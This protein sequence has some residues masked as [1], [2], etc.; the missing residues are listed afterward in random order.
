VL[1]GHVDAASIVSEI[2]HPRMQIAAHAGS[3]IGALST[4]S[5]AFALGCTSAVTRCPGFSRHRHYP[6]VLMGG[7]EGRVG[8]L[9]GAGGAEGWLSDYLTL[10]GLP[11]EVS[12]PAL[13]V[14][15]GLT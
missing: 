5:R 14:G 10:M 3:V 12:P 2:W 9:Y 11:F 15:T 1:D 7:A 4:G 6:R 13:S 8:P